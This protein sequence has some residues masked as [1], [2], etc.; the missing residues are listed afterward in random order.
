M[1]GNKELQGAQRDMAGPAVG[2][3]RA[4]LGKTAAIAG[5]VVLASQITKIPW[6]SA[7]HAAAS[8]PSDEVPQWA[9]VIDL[10]RCDGCDDCSKACQ[11]TH[12]TG[13]QKWLEVF[14]V[15]DEGGGHYFLPRPCMQCENA[16]CENV[17][18]VGA[19]F[20]NESGAVLI[21]HRI[22]IGCRICIAAC[23]YGA[24]SFN[25][26][27]P[28]NPPGARFAKY[29]PEFPVP[30]R[31]G[32]AE[33]CMFCV[34]N[35]KMG[36]LPACATACAMSAIWLGDLVQDVA[37][38]GLETVKLSWLLSSRHAFRLKEELGTRPRVWYLPGHGE[39]AKTVTP[40]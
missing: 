12:F 8:D 33:K 15:H 16:P 1:D 30:H 20:T 11:K 19:T 2:S 32:T 40:V 39:E 31:K 37:T 10:A 4:F 6:E 17:C 29:S 28:E 14:K 36:K 23:P 13:D 7:A 9:M 35:T 25:W 21:D 38:N 27:V 22:C 5:S 24:R 18:P 26:G 3:R 34:H